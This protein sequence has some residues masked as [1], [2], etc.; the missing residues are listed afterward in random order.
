MTAK[1][2]AGRPRWFNITVLVS[3]LV[4]FAVLV[5]LGNWQVRRLSWK[6]D[7]IEAV[8]TR[9][10]AAPVAPPAT[11]LPDEHAYL[12]VGISGM[13]LHDL[14]RRV[15]AV[16]EL[17]PGHWLLTPLQGSER[18]IWV[19]RGFLAT[20]QPEDSI[21]APTG[22]VEVTGLLR[23]TEP[24]GT[25]LE[26]NAPESERWVSRDTAALSVSAGFGET[27]NFFVDADHSGPP[28]AWPR[29]GMTVI[30]FRNSHLSYAL[31]WYAMA[32]LFLVGFGLA[33][34]DLRRAGRTAD[35]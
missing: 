22:T 32:A 4:I 25:L 8:E 15:K 28:D 16:T 9:A 17:G 18:T 34:T 23:M 13:Y 2:G 14:S 20:G 7:L 3:C 21:Y 1:T 31:T 5:G 10:F 24:K 30:A 6:L 19:N 27:S 12:R 26:R 29:G 33:L 35:H 11:A